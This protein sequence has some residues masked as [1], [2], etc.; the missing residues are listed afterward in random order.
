MERKEES[1][2]ENTALSDQNNQMIPSNSFSFSMAN[3]IFDIP[4]EADQ[5]GSLGFIDM[6]NAQDF[7]GPSIF[8]L[9]QT[10]PLIP[11][12]SQ[13]QPQPLLSPPSTVPESSEVVDTPASPNSSSM[14]SS[15]NE[16]AN[17]KQT[18]T[19][20]EEQNDQEKT[21]KQLKPK[22]KNQKRQREPRF[23]FMTKSEIDNLDDG[24]R[25]RKY[26]Q[27][28]VKNSPFP[29]S[30]YRCTST[31][32]GVKKRVERSSEDP[33]IVVTTYEGTHTH[34]CPITPRG[35]FGIMPGNTTFGGGGSS[36]GGGG[37][38]GRGGSFFA[39]PQV[40]HYQNQQHQIQQQPYFHNL[41]P[42]LSFTNTSPLVP[43]PHQERPFYPS[44]TP[45]AR[46]HGLLEDMLPSQIL[47]ETKEE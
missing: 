10:P 9:L 25:W 35:S 8:D 18:K 31:A 21:K 40:I 36:S 22:K 12:Q 1:S 13:L 39:I 42:P 6:L 29:R 11:L 4:C 32:C 47:K 19:V 41:T 5:K 14:S 38:R 43:R 15:S 17:D 24:Y 26:G 3:S 33:S 2:T 16:A 44:A 45:L 28:A 20:D 46:D 37:D 27:K 30:Y 34:P 23:A 7:A